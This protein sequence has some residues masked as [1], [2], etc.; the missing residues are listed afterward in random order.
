[1]FPFATNAKEDGQGMVNLEERIHRVFDSMSSALTPEAIEQYEKSRWTKFF[2][3]FGWEHVGSLDFAHRRKREIVEGNFDLI[4]I[5]KKFNDRYFAKYAKC[6]SEF[7]E[8][9]ADVFLQRL[10]GMATVQLQTIASPNGKH[11]IAILTIIATTHENINFQLQCEFENGVYWL[12]RPSVSVESIR[13]NPVA[14]TILNTFQEVTEHELPIKNTKEQTEIKPNVI[15]NRFYGKTEIL[16]V[17]VLFFSY[18][19]IIPCIAGPLFLFDIIKTADGRP[20]HIAGIPLTIL[21]FLFMPFVI[22][23]VFHLIIRQKPLIRL[24]KE[25]IQLMDVVLPTPIDL[26]RLVTLKEFRI[27]TLRLE[28]EK[29]D[30][31]F[32]G[33]GTLGII[34]NST[35][36]ENQPIDK[37]DSPIQ[38]FSYDTDSFAM[39]LKNV[40]DILCYFHYNSEARRILPSWKNKFPSVNRNPNDSLDVNHS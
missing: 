13:N 8:S 6:K 19:S 26:C 22:T 21:G 11:N 32:C 2:R 7:K 17:F 9:W 28:W 36:T 34:G 20:G 40:G 3:L 5:R 30:T 33:H 37:N 39:P 15:S 1:M 25:G 27:Q 23:F 18:V 14:R 24:Y 4:P 38:I 12:E 10:E 35:H 31:I 16:W 29:I